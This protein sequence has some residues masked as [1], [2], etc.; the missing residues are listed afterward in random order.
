MVTSVPKKV[1]VRGVVEPTA[2][3]SLAVLAQSWSEV[4]WV[5]TPS[6]SPTVMTIETIFVVT[7]LMMM[8]D[9]TDRMT[10]TPISPIATLFADSY[11]IASIG[12]PYVVA[13]DR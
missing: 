12:A 4:R 1:Q 9:T 3:R 6:A 10:K 11:P 7:F 13:F 8:A 2:V 5:Q